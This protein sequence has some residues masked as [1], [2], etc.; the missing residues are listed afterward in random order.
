MRLALERRD[1]AWPDYV[2]RLERQRDRAARKMRTPA[3][4]PGPD[5][6][7]AAAGLLLVGSCEPIPEGPDVAGCRSSDTLPAAGPDDDDDARARSP[8]SRAVGP[9]DEEASGPGED[10]RRCVASSNG[11]DVAAQK[12]DYEPS[13]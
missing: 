9:G 5:A 11:R 3:L 2:K 6:A 13:S 12:E 10:L 8:G 4:E 1:R 7:A